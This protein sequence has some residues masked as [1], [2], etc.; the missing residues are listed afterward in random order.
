[1]IKFILLSCVFVS[2]CNCSESKDTV[3]KAVFSEMPNLLYIK[4][5][6][7]STHSYYGQPNHIDSIMSYTKGVKEWV[8]IFKQ[9]SLK[10]TKYFS[11]DGR[12]VELHFVKDSLITSEGGGELCTDLFYHYDNNGRITVKG[13]QGVYMGAGVPVGTWSYFHDNKLIRTVF[14]HNDILGKDYMRHT[15]YAPDGSTR[16]ITTNNFMLY[17]TDSVTISNRTP[18]KDH[19]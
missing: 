13:C 9:D 19:P 7:N 17:E 3:P 6:G 5:V 12:V 8:K 1:M 16:V 2:A 10:H 11:P 14:H 4:T 15:L 18:Q